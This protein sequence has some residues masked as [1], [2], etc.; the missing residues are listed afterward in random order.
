MSDR[1]STEN[2]QGKLF[3]YDGN[4]P[5]LH[6]SKERILELEKLLHHHNH[7]Y[8]T[9]G[10]TE[11]TDDEY[12]RLKDELEKLDPENSLLYQVG[13]A[14]RIEAAKITHSVELLSLDKTHTFED[15]EK[16]AREMNDFVVQP[17]LDGLA[18]SIFYDE[19]KFSYAAT[20]G[21]GK[22]GEDIT[23]NARFIDDIPEK[24]TV[25]ATCHIR[26]EIF[27]RRSVFDEF[28]GEFSNPRNAAAGSVKQKDPRITGE[29]KLSFYA[30]S[31][32]MDNAE[33]DR[34]EKI[35]RE[36]FPD[37]QG[38]CG[39]EYN[40]MQLVR[41]LGI[42]PA[43]IERTD[44][45]GLKD[46]FD[47][48]DD[49]RSGDIDFEIDGMVIKI[50]DLSVQKELGATH[51]HPRWAVA[52][53]FTAQQAITRIEKIRWQVSR[54]GNLT[55]VADLETVNL[56]G[57]NISHS[58]LH[59]ADEL[60][61]LNVN[62]GDSVLIE[63]RGDVIPKVIRVTEKG[64][65]EGPAPMPDE[66]PRC[67]SEVRKENVFLR[68]TNPNCSHRVL[69]QLYH[70]ADVAD[71]ETVGP[72]IIEK[73]Y[74]KDIL[75]TPADFYKLEEKDLIPLEKIGDVLAKKILI[76]IEKRRTLPLSKFLTA[77]GITHLGDVMA[78]AIAKRFG[79]L[80]SIREAPREDL[81]EIDVVGEKIADAVLAELKEKWPI[82]E[83]MRSL[84]ITVEK[85]YVSGSE[86][87][88][89]GDEEPVKGRSFCI[90]GTLSRPRKYF[91]DI[92]RE[93]G[94][95]VK[96]MSKSVDYLLAGDRPGSKVE[97]AKNLGVSV[98]SEEE[99]MGMMGEAEKK[100]VLL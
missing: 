97:K 14:P 10:T 66:C 2:K 15:V 98:I 41:F 37:F 22:V 32:V 58:T 13:D 73:L 36:R 3:D 83:E 79:D 19:G 21:D 11:I 75:A 100:D 62:V 17:K 72:S 71:L 67:G 87:G 92:I 65:N 16:W 94:G 91:E 68:C 20:R 48:W 85:I 6:D 60:V 56:A 70:F 9:R 90:T 40:M 93:A 42:E 47:R 89:D 55:P 28:A 5:P 29:R 23:E 46:I 53:K 78:E 18:V 54:T 51:H 34:V 99:F 96:G 64:P 44:L 43:K 33:I 7:L 31:L 69:R 80:D 74:E 76:N 59:N 77:L 86:A 45:P 8:Y 84:G 52:W 26:G 95:T 39:Q 27:M 35:L 50:N 4:R 25:D 1:K 63:R 12:D 30:Y 57:A 88:G 61:R 38:I 81:L 49:A 24:L 82:I